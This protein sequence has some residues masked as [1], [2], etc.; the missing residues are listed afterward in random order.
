M[1]SEEVENMRGL[2]KVYRDGTI[3]RVEDP[4]MFVKASLQGEGDVASKDIV[5]NEKLGLWVRLYL[6]S[7]HLQQQT[8]KRRLPLIVYFHGGGFCLASPALPDFHNFTLKLAA[9]VGAIVVSVA[10]RLAPEHRLPAA[11]DDGITALQWVSSHAVH[12]GDYEH[13]PWL[14]SHADFSQ[15][16]L[17]GDSAG[18]N[19]AHHAVAECGGVE[20]WSPMRVRGAIFVQPYFGAEKRTRSESECPPD[21][22]FTLQ[23]S[24]ACWRVSLPVGSNRDHPFSNPWSDGAP[25]LEEVPLPPLLVAIGGR[26]VLRD[27]GLDYCESLKQCGKSVEVMVLEEEEH[28]FYALKPHSQSSERLM[29]RISRFISSSPLESAIHNNDV[30]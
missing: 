10:Y 23:L 20:A 28:A 4:R 5:L 16:Y 29:E 26:D 11:Y 30:A 8:E 3:F 15:V 7:S 2:L 18:A 9:S 6:P 21:A 12:G 1:D 24:D 25:K 14:D 22:F 13:D 27:R 17:L 19:I